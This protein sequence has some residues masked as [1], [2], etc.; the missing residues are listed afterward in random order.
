M[1]CGGSK[2]SDC[3]TNQLSPSVQMVCYTVMSLIKNSVCLLIDQDQKQCR[4]IHQVKKDFC[5]T[6]SAEYAML[7]M[8]TPED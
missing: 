6:E 3:V 8:Q 5:T 4:A 1:V 2:A 7:M